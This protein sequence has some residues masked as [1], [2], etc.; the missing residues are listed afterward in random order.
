MRLP[1]G[2]QCVH[3]GQQLFEGM[4]ALTGADSKV[5]AFRPL[6][7]ARRMNRG[8]VYMRGPIVPDEVA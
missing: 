1:E 6:D 5:Y 4:K 3:Y 7:N 2:S 8:A